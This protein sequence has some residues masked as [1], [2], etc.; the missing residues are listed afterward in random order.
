MN[1]LFVAV[2]GLSLVV[3]FRVYSLVAVCGFLISVASLV[4]R[5][6]SRASGLGPD[7]ERTVVKKTKLLPS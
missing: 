5:M 3:E 6:C 1:R 4:G 7:T 2:Y